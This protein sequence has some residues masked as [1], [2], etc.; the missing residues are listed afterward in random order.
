MPLNPRRPR[1]EARRVTELIRALMLERKL[2]KHDA[3][4]RAQIE[5]LQRERLRETVD[6]A[7][8][9][10]RFYRELYSGIAEPATAELGRLP[11]VSKQDLMERFE[12]W[13][14][15]DHLRLTDVQDH[16]ASFRGPDGYYSRRYRVITTGGSSGR[17]AAFAFSS[18]EWSVVQAHL[19]RFMELIGVSFRPGR[20]IKSASVAAGHPLHVTYRAAV[21]VDVGAMRILRL[22]ATTP[23]AELVEALNA[24]QPEWLHAYP[25]VG[26]LLA[27]EQ[28][29]GRLH[30]SP[31]VVSTSSELRTPEMSERMRA[32][33]G[34]LPF[35]MYGIT[36]AGIFA[37]EC[38]QHRLHAIDDEFIFEVVDEENNPVPAG[39]AGRKLLITNLYMR[40]QPLIRYEVGDM[41]AVS[42]EA[43]PCGRPFPV[44]ESVEGRSDD[45]L[46]LP[47]GRG[48]ELPVHPMHFRSPLAADKGVRQYEVIQRQDD[49]LV[50][51]VPA[52]GADAAEL[53]HRVMSV[54]RDELEAAGVA[55]PP[56]EVELVDTI[57]RDPERMSKL[58]LVRSEASR[59]RAWKC[60]RDY[61]SFRS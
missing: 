1:Y 27:D 52:R 46:Y 18:R 50:R 13:A 39:E 54:L 45:V 14:T 56:L 33:W 53:K 8:N 5:T 12:D 25:S 24:F 28:I 47:D 15:D 43:C 30:I 42:P 34:S 57:E 22:E 49:I 23:L 26:A 7:I 6:F 10:S 2:R 41:I 44:L 4:S 9:H 35:D 17:K 37:M 19:L 32:A 58:K 61:F 16:L 21:S 20:R 3:W 11:I 31:R 29:E 40:T 48:G 55:P 36:E 59:T 51:V 60:V 38:E